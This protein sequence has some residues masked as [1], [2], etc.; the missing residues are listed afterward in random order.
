MHMRTQIDRHEN[1][2]KN[3]ATIE[4]FINKGVLLMKLRK[5]SY[6]LVRMLLFV[7]LFI[8]MVTE[9]VKTAIS[10]NSNQEKKPTSLQ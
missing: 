3:Y 2:V 1:Y 9:T 4:V 8:P 7:S 10:D 6:S 5:C